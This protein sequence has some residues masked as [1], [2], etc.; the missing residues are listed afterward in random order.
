MFKSIEFK[1]LLNVA[2][3][4]ILA[5]LIA[6][7]PIAFSNSQYLKIDGFTFI[8]IKRVLT[9]PLW[10]KAIR[11]S[12]L[13]AACSAFL[14]VILAV[15]TIQSLSR[16]TKKFKEITF[17]VAVF[18]LGMPVIIFAL[19]LLKWFYALNIFDNLLGLTLAHCVLSF[20]IALL[21]INNF[22]SRFFKTH[23]NIEG[24]ANL[25]GLK[26]MQFFR[27]ITLPNIFP[28]IIKSLFLS[29]AVSF[30]EGVIVQ[31]LSGER[32]LTISKKLFD[33]LRFE[34]NPEIAA[35]SLMLMLLCTIGFIIIHYWF[36]TY[37]GTNKL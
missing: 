28:S 25:M 20:P 27:L 29:F 16:K 33:G 3:A 2:I 32:T 5:P 31:L 35:V 15:L 22:T 34:I 21:M 36:K 37:Y 6:I 30:N 23:P 17:I 18:P 4:F 19:A 14:S 12:F 11:N 26:G 7:I 9:D 13:I 10:N 1:I 8:W 24:A